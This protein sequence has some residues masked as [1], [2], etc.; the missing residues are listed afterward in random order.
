MTFV[1]R[2]AVLALC[3]IAT[4]A[5]RASAQ[6]EA[7][8]KV[9][10]L[11]ASA[12]Y[13][14]ALAAMPALEDSTRASTEL[15]RYRALCLLALGREDQA[16]AAVERLVRDHP[17]FVSSPSDTSPRMQAL[18]T[19][20]RVRVLPGLAKEAYAS[21]KS[22]YEAR[23]WPAASAGF[24]RT[25]DLLGAIPAEPRAALADLELLTT[26]F[27]D[28]TRALSAPRPEASAANGSA[29][30]AGPELPQTTPPTPIRQ[31]MPEWVPPGSMAAG[32]EFVGMIRLQIGADGRVQSATV[33]KPSHPAYDAAILRAATEW[34]YQP[35]TVG[36]RAVPS[37]KTIAVRL[38]PR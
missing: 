31:D 30:P 18:F 13:E 19:A 20:A 29:P 15:E 21:A 11:Y 4:F 1:T 17:E 26:E 32:Q 34:L 2:A 14:D 10:A 27:L 12:A 8:E 33:V 16:A 38:R 3:V 22:A 28:L 24:R 23:D 37:E 7:V 9:R 6:D 36:G 5:S 35:G 25:L